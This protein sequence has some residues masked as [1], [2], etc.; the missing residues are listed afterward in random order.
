[1]D[2]KPC[3][4]IVRNILVDSCLAAH[5]LPLCIDD[6][7]KPARSTCTSW[8][9]VTNEQLGR[10]M[11][12]TGFSKNWSVILQQVHELYP[13]RPISP[14]A[15]V[16][17]IAHDEGLHP[18]HLQRVQAVELGDYNKRMDF[19]RWFLHESNADRNFAASVLFTDEA[20]FSLEGVM[21]F[22]NLHTWADEN[23]HT[24]R[25]HGAQ[26]KCSINV[27]AGIV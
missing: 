1:M 5:S 26:R 23:P 13:E 25:P 19:A 4:C 10:L 27:W 3:E 17:R 15:T 12:K 20:T 6:C 16:W 2:E 8:I 9:L 22:H 11:L 18:Y 24:I 21:N 14:Q 7:V